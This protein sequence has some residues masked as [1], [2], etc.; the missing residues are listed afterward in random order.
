MRSRQSSYKGRYGS[1]SP[2]RSRMVSRETSVERDVE[3]LLT[4]TEKQVLEKVRKK[5]AK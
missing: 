4:K 1:K 3:S 2:M 5:G